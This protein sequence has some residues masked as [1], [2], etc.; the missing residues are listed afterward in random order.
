[1]LRKSRPCIR[2]IIKGWVGFVLTS[3]RRMFELAVAG[4]INLLMFLH[5]NPPP[6]LRCVLRMKS[7]TNSCASAGWQPSAKNG[8]VYCADGVLP[9][10]REPRILMALGILTV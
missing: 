1:V 2:A 8:S 9:K 10:G 4:N 7:L 5:N 3:R 6:L